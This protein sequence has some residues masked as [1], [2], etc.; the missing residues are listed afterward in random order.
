MKRVKEKKP[1]IRLI[2]TE[3]DG[4][5]LQLLAALAMRPELLSPDLLRS[6]VHEFEALKA[7]V[8]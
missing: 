5:R 7:R 6:I 3:E 8:N 1:V 2:M 4:S